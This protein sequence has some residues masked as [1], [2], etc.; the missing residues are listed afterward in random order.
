MYRDYAISPTMFHWESQSTTS[1]SSETGQRYINHAERGNRILL[2]AREVSNRR[3]FLYL[4]P[5]QYVRH[6][7]DRPISIVWRLERELPPRFFLEARAVS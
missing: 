5:A 6:T 7:G 4:G 3:D 1:V 2:F